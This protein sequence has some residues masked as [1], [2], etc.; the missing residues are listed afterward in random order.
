M[1]KPADLKYFWS[2]G[3]AWDFTFPSNIKC[4]YQNSQQIH[5]W[6]ATVLS[7]CSYHSNICTYSVDPLKNYVDI[8]KPLRIG[9]N[10]HSVNIFSMSPQGIEYL[11]TAIRRINIIIIF[12]LLTN[13]NPPIILLHCLWLWLIVLNLYL[14]DFSHG[15]SHPQSQSLA[16]NTL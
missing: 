16:E 1:K 6:T 8:V 14:S 2:F 12:C 9:K 13:L 11:V 3:C 10:H 5:N 7:F 15:L 4:S